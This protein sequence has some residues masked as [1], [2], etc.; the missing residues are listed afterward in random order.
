MTAKTAQLKPLEIDPDALIEKLSTIQSQ[1]DGDLARVIE[2]LLLENH[3]LAID[4]SKGLRR[5][6]NFEFSQF[7]RFLEIK[8]CEDGK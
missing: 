5:G 4:Q 6:G 7:P 3:V 1:A 8:S 2:L